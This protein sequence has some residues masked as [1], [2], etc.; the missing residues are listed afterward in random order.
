MKCEMSFIFLY[1]GRL[2]CATVGSN[3]GGATWAIQGVDVLC[4][5]S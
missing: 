1:L 5:Y 4:Y 3:S 2:S